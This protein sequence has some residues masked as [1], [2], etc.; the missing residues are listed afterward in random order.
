MLRSTL[1][2]GV[3]LSVL[4]GCSGVVTEPDGGSDAPD[5]SAEVDAGS[6]LDAGTSVDS[7]VTVDAGVDAGST[8]ADAG[9]DAGVR[10][11]LDAGPYDAGLF[12]AGT[13]AW[14]D[15]G[16][17]AWRNGLALNQ[18]VEIPGTSGA[19]GAA[20]DAWGALAENKATAELYIA[21]S[22]GHSDSADNRVVSISLMADAP[23]WVQRHA[24]STN[25]PVNVL[26]YPDGLPTSRHL[27]HHL[28]FLPA[29]NVVLLGGC[30]YGYG[31]NTP[32][33]PGMDAFSLTT[34]AWLPRYTFPDI[35][36]YNGYVIE[37]DGAGRA[38]TQSGNRFDPSTNRW[39]TPGSGP[40]LGRFPH[41][42]APSRNLIFSLQFGDGQGYDLNLGVVARKLDTTTGNSV[43][44]TFNP[45]T[46]L[47]EFM[48]AQP[49]YAGM[50]YDAANDRF[51][52]THHAERGKVYVVTPN[53]TTT[54][55]LSVLTTTGMPTVTSGAGINK[56]FRYLPTLGG[57][58][59]LPSRSSNLYFLRTN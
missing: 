3:L 45:S 19:G 52:F 46:A 43:A 2:C 58:V 42:T 50:D 29:L 56:R 40:G 1:L 7:G 13:W 10:P 31:G 54:W 18:W 26:Y 44:I 17:P 37:I 59:L 35:T 11:I 55:D 33:G 24:S 28:H 25:T 20:I 30:R 8:V 41:A 49:T 9:V 53:A 47:T 34:N 16:G 14:T 4:V 15:G 12:D 51:L 36:P 57:F 5:A 23:A 39:S 6:E 32:T 48:A 27:Y 22:G 21:A 38:W